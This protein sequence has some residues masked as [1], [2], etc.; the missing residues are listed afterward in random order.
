M[1]RLC[2]CIMSK[3]KIV[4]NLTQANI[5]PETADILRAVNLKYSLDDNYNRGL[6]ETLILDKLISCVLLDY[7]RR[8][9]HLGKYKLSLMISASDKLYVK[10]KLD[11]LQSSKDLNYLK[12]LTV[13][14]DENIKESFRMQQRRI[15]QSL[16][17]KLLIIPLEELDLHSFSYEDFDGTII[18]RT[19]KS[20]VGLWHKINSMYLF[21]SFY[22][23]EK[24]HPMLFNALYL[25]L[26]DTKQI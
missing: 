26:H 23:L 3:S 13:I 4:N 21:L 25:Y 17:I 5:S 6:A 8:S 16:I 9:K 11:N 7:I 20:C 15:A 1:V 19:G 12:M 22:Y 24:Q 14:G 18:N 10:E 2:L